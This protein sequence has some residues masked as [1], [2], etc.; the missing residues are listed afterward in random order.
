MKQQISGLR[1]GIL[2]GGQLG[3][4]L[5]P[6]C[7][8][9]NLEI[10]VL[11]PDIACPC[12]K[13]CDR[14]V[15]GSLLDFDT[16]YSFGKGLDVIT[17]EIE[18]VNADAL[19]QLEQEGVLVYPQPSVI[20]TV[21]DKGLQK[22]FYSE[23]DI[24]TAAFSL[25]ESKQ[26]LL[27]SLPA[28]PFVQKMRTAGYDGKGVQVVRS[29]QD[30]DK[31]F[32]VPSVIEDAVDIDK[33]LSVLVARNAAGEI[34]AFPIVEL[35][36]DPEANLVDYLVSPA[37]V[38]PQ[39]ASRAKDVAIKVIS[40]LNMVGL[41]AVELFLDKKGHLLVNEIAPRPHNSG[42]QSI[43]AN[44]TSQYLQHLRAICNLPLG[45]TRATSAAVM[46]NLLGEKGSQGPVVCDGIEAVMDMPGAYL[47][48]YGKKT[49]RPFRKMGHITILAD[50]L[51]E[52]MQSAKQL[53][54]VFKIKG[55]ESC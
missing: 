41:L 27:N 48:L 46:L 44:I 2:G 47:H 30:L 36:Y 22:Q 20:K 3:R 19:A 15:C 28:F 11:D 26:E 35:V 50:T 49:S 33:E 25:V 23:H 4:M 45:D 42:H 17:I 12:S 32:D 54:K 29:A 34:K 52:A 18:H 37:S 21:Q 9:L 14:F 1:L 7:I 51:D 13:L 24:P 5:I 16:V 10:S 43:E 38:S 55:S 53:K 40:T 31:A 39:V 6:E 8:K